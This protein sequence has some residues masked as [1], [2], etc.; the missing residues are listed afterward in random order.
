[1]ACGGQMNTNK[2]ES[3]A[4]NRFSQRTVSETSTTR[5]RKLLLQQRIAHIVGRGLSISIFSS[6]NG[7]KRTVL[8]FRHGTSVKPA[9][10][11]FSSPPRNQLTACL[12]NE[13]FYFNVHFNCLVDDP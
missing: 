2:L 11:N 7:C 8:H 9:G 5:N 4:L 12:T 1:M 13:R 6:S 10:K 3:L